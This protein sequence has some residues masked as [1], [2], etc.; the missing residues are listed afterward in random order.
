[1]NAT[2]SLP[3][4]D[5]ATHSL[6]NVAEWIFSLPHAS[7]YA[8][9]NSALLDPGM[10]E[11]AFASHCKDGRYHAISEATLGG[12]FDHGYF[13]LEN[14]HTGAVAVQ[15][16]FFVDQDLLAGLPAQV[17]HPFVALRRFW[18]RLLTL[19]MLMVGCSSGEGQ[20]DCD[21]PWAVEV[22]HES[23]DVYAKK[24]GASM[25]LLKD[26]PA[27]YRRALGCFSRNGYSRAP[28][29][30]GAGMPIDFANFEE[31]MQRKLGKIYRKNLRR[32]FK[33]NAKSPPITMEVVNDVT[34]CVDEI[35]GLYL[36][37]FNRSEFK[38]EKLTPEYFCA[39]GQRM[40]DRTRYFLWRQEGR[41]IAFSLC[42][43]HDGT[44]HDMNV[45]M[46]YVVA[47]DLHLYFV[48]FHDIIQ[49]A[50]ENGLRHYCTGP[51]NYDPKLHLRLQLDPLDLYA[52][53]TSRWIAPLFKFA[54][55]Y[56]QPARHDKTI[57]RFR[58]A[59]EL[60]S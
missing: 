18:P 53:H 52:R 32:K 12:Q 58:N 39:L 14:K 24:Q 17:R 19:R 5:A 8:V 21:E 15:Q 37:T 40:P 60:Y 55:N 6:R 29:M 31:F 13:V 26:F 41:I 20:L 28:S 27:R 57:R 9:K 59:H 51:L 34:A 56:L 25:I 47:L 7:V 3:T 48:T 45:G 23:L 35:Y 22:L 54:L 2:A 16:F 4:T 50:A 42:L 33:G 11:N 46:D 10:L 38:F 36:Q 43:V 30:P 44:I 1:M 49:W